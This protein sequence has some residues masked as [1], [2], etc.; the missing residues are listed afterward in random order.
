MS[1]VARFLLGCI[2]SIIGVTITGLIFIL[3]FYGI[4][5][6]TNYRILP[7]GPAWLL[8]PIAVGL[9]SFHIFYHYEIILRWKI[10]SVETKFDRLRVVLSLCWFVGSFL[11][12]YTSRYFNYLDILDV[13]RWGNLEREAL[14]L[15]FLPTGLFFFGVPVIEKILK[16]IVAGK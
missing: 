5:E 6:I 12:I 1:P 10:F 13:F 15:V 4:S 7:R 3:I 8:I 2:G 11:Y 16:W 14:M 9:G